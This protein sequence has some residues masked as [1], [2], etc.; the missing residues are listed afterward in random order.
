MI[1]GLVR[2]IDLASLEEIFALAIRKISSFRVVLIG[3][4]HAAMKQ[5][6]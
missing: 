5:F 2:R 6:P 4:E 1:S 3:E